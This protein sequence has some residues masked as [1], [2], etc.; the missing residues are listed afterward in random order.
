MTLEQE[1]RIKKILIGVAVFIFISTLIIVGIKL[2]QKEKMKQLSMEENA[3][4]VVS[5]E[6]VIEEEEIQVVKKS[7]AEE[8]TNNYSI[9]ETSNYSKNIINLYP[10]I[11]ESSEKAYR[12]NKER[13]KK[14]SEA[15]LQEVEYVPTL[16]ENG[17]IIVKKNS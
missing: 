14:I 17:K 15:G 16:N 2:I 1:E 9:I 13:K 8:K 3:E 11:I 7:D 5:E 6:V 10:N 4:Q 12:E